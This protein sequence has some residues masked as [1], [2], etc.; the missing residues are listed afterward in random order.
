MQGNIRRCSGYGVVGVLVAE[1]VDVEV[2]AG[3]VGRKRR[4]MGGDVVALPGRGGLKEGVAFIPR[5]REV[6]HTLIGDHL[7]RLRDDAVLKH[8][9]LKVEDVVNNDLAPGRRQ[10]HD[11]MGVGSIRTKGRGK[12]EGGVGGHVVDELG[13]GG[14]LAEAPALRAVQHVNVRWQ[15]SR[16][17]GQEVQ[18]NGVRQD[19]NLDAR[20]CVL[21]VRLAE[22]LDTVRGDPSVVDKFVGPGISWRTHIDHVRKLG[23]LNDEVGRK[24]AGDGPELGRIEENAAVSLNKGED[25]CGRDGDMKYG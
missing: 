11:V 5:R 6:E 10:L 1:G 25:V 24:L 7:H 12:V 14:S 17:L 13:H 15:V 9:L 18:T 4:P 22:S 21:G 3:K 20:A 19:A 2:A 8:G 16:C 23:Q